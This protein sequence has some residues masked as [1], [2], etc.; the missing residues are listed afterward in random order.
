MAYNYQSAYRKVKKEILQMIDYNTEHMVLNASFCLDKFNLT[1]DQL[2]E[3]LYNLSYDEGYIEP[4]GGHVFYQIYQP[5]DDDKREL[6][7]VTKFANNYKFKNLLINSFMTDFAE[8]YDDD[9]DN[10]LGSKDYLRGDCH[11]DDVFDLIIL[12]KN[13]FQN[14]PLD[15]LQKSAGVAYQTDDFNSDRATVSKLNSNHIP[16]ILIDN[17][18]L[19]HDDYPN[20]TNFSL[21]YELNHNNTKTNYLNFINSYYQTLDNVLLMFR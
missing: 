10:I 19:F 15:R 6:F 8:F 2:D 11:R 17:K 13:D 7:L 14:I 4:G 18:K 3:I 20:I 21:K 1:D 9:N 12:N 5:Y 16:L